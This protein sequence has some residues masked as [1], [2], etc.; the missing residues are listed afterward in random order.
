MAW[1]DACTTGIF[2][3]RPPARDARSIRFDAWS[4]TSRIRTSLPLPARDDGRHGGQQ[5]VDQ[6]VVYGLG[7]GLIFFGDTPLHLFGSTCLL[8]IVQCVQRAPLFA[9][10]QNRTD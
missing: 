1:I 6:E 10:Q 8:T 5:I 2:A 9:P 4:K 7:D 3:K